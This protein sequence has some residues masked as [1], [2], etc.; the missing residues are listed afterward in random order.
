M[1]A[2]DVARAVGSCVFYCIVGP[3]IIFLNKHILS[4]L[5]FNFPVLLSLMGMICS[6]IV[7]WV[8]CT[9]G[10]V[11]RKNAS[12]VTTKFYLRNIMP[13][14]LI[15]GLTLWTGNLAYIYISVAYIQM[16][17]ASSPV[18][19]MGMTFMMGMETP[20]RD[21]ILSVCLITIGTGIASFGALDFSLFGFLVMM[22]SN[23]CECTRLIMQQR[24]LT[25]FKFGIV[26]GIYYI[27]PSASFWLFCM[28]A[29]VEMR[30][31]FDDDGATILR[32]NIGAFVGASVFGFLINFAGFLVIKHCSALTLKV[33][34]NARNAAIVLIA[35]VAL[36]EPVT[37]QQVLGYSITIVGFM[38][39]NHAKAKASAPG[40]DTC[41]D[42][43]ATQ[44]QAQHKTYAVLPT[45][46]SQTARSVSPQTS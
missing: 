10:L 4:A 16:L 2:G 28:F 37:Q 13:I 42:V 45:S 41:A 35:A 30:R 12:K 44:G 26:E 27:Y 23:I 8:L 21:L 40:R 1:A 43:G 14:G 6:S 29:G 15:I 22:A 38:Y 25:D 33:L 34:S 32:E 36:A 9:V 24:L 5:N 46:E 7:S 20:Q 3:C 31:F 17:K 18:I 39:Y 19:M 11:E